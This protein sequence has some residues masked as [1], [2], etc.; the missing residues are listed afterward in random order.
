M[1]EKPTITEAREALALFADG[2]FERAD[3]VEHSKLVAAYV[4]AVIRDDRKNRRPA[5]EPSLLDRVFGRL[6]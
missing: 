5:E 3:R 1:V 2:K 4:A 6:R